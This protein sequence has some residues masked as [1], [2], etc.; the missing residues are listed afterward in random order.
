V[1]FSKKCF[2]KPAMGKAASEAPPEPAVEVFASAATTVPVAARRSPPV[3]AT[4][5]KPAE[6]RRQVRR[7][8]AAEVED[9]SS[10]AGS[11]GIRFRRAMPQCGT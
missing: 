10:M 2:S 6:R 9:R 1:Y 11:K 3:T 8:P 5:A 4:A 7:V